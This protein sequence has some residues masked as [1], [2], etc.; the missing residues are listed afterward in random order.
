[1]RNFVSLSAA[2]VVFCL[3]APRF[4]QAQQERGPRDADRALQLSTAG[5][6][7]VTAALGTLVAINKPT[8]FSEGRCAEGSPIFGDYGCHGLSTLH[9]M[10]ALLSAVLYTATAT[11]EFSAFDWPGRDRHGDA[12]EALSYV[13]LVGMAVQPI[14]GLLAAV[15]EVVGASRNGTFARV[16]RTIHLFT[17]YAIVGSFVVTTAIEL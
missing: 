3:A 7:I 12:Y 17:G 13:H 2:L 6:L 16:L 9:G 14:A 4:V 5:S 1:M 8:L 15:P 11:L 10:F